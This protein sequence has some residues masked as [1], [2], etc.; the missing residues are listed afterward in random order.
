[1]RNM[2]TYHM[3]DLNYADIGY[4]FVV[5][6]DGNIY[7]GRG[8]Y[9]VGSHTKNWNEKS[10]CV[11]FIGDYGEMNATEKQLEAT[12]LL[13]AEGVERKLL[14]ETYRLYGHFQVKQNTLSPG[15]NLYNIIKTWNHWTSS[16]Y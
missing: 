10:I 12:Q 6:G 16:L 8:W 5:G 7:V 4:N 1:M 11:A 3:D 9:K 15:I 14:S 2:Q 13:L